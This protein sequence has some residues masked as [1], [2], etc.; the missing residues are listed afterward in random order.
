MASEIKKYNKRLAALK[1]ERSSFITAWMELSD[2]HLSHR[3]RFL[4]SDRNKGSRHNN[5]QINN[6]SRL[7]ARTLASGMMAGITSPARPWF[8]LSTSNPQLK[9]IAAVKEWLHQAQVTMYEVFAQSNFYNSI[10]SLYVELGV[11]ATAPMGI[12]DDFENVIHCQTYTVGSYMLA[13]NGKNEVDTLYRE[14]ERSV[15]QLV[16]QFGIDNVSNAVKKQWESGN[17]EQWVKIVHIIEPNDDRDRMSPMA[18]DMP[19]RS[20]YYEIGSETEREDKFLK[21]SGFKTFPIVAPRWE[22]TGEDIY[23]TD[24]PGMMAL[25]DTKALQLAERRS[26]QAVDKM[27][28]PPLQGPVSLRSKVGD[29]LRSGEIVWVPQASQG[30]KSIYDFRPDIPAI[31]AK[32]AQAENRISRAFYED[33]FLMLANTDRKQITAREIAEKHEEKLLMLGPVLER[34]HTELLD[35]IIDITFE[36]LQSNGVLPPPPPELQGLDLKIE[37]VSVLAQAQRLVAVGGL[38]R[39]SGYVGNLAQIWPEARF[40][41]DAMQ[42][43]DEYAD[44]IGVTPGVVRSDDR[45]QE[46][47]Q[48]EQQAAQQQAAMQ[49]G[50]DLAKVAKDVSQTDL[51]EDNALGTTMRRAGLI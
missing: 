17:T 14:Y 21:R 19:F 15:A 38:E 48:A 28:N 10:H 25:G 32:I 43:V 3:G 16:K 44:S 5:K 30:L 26:F 34:L 7:A 1:S 8:R 18:K 29:S 6:K 37:Y 46:M 50:Q 39:L 49:Q 35:P 45:V 27:L 24:C 41:F 36:K 9:E 2:N 12:Y 47:Q 33:L 20:V 51:S 4:T 22:I 40:K 23:G 13:A 31:E 11:F 42:S